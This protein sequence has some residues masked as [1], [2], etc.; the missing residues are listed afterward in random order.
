MKGIFTRIDLIVGYIVGFFVG[1][2]G[3]DVDDEATGGLDLG[4]SGTL[5]DGIDDGTT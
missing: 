5:D 3:I 2:E 4:G 1:T